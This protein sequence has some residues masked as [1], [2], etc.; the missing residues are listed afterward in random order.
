MSSSFSVF[1]L[2]ACIGSFLNV[3]IYRIP[4]GESIVSPGIEM[5]RLPKRHPL[6]PEHPHPQLVFSARPLRGLRGAY[7]PPLPAGG[8][9]DRGISSSWSSCASASTWAT[10]VYW[11][12]AAALVAITFIDLDHQIIPDVISLPGIPIGFACSFLVP[13]ISWSDS[14]IG[15]LPAAAAFIWLRPAMSC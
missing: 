14:L 6:V 7:F 1:I 2:G 13:W 9:A 12:F 15:I 10:P 5:P 8:S 11:L 3:C 4:A